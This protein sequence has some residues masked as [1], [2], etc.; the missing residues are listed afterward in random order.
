MDKEAKEKESK[1][2]EQAKET[3]EKDKPEVYDASK[4]TVLGGLDAVRKRPSMYIGSTSSTGLH[5][6]V[7]EVVDNSIDEAMAG[8]C[9]EI[10]ITLA[11]DNSVTVEDNGR[12]IPAEIHPKYKVNCIELV[13]T[14]LHAGG[15]FDKKAYKVSGGLHG[16]GVSVV[17]ALSEVLE[18]WGYRDNS[19]YYQKYCRGKPAAAVKSIGK[20]EGTRTGTKVRFLADKEIFEEGINYSNDILENSFREL[21]FLNKGLKIIFIDEKNNLRHEF[22]YEGGLRSFVEFINKNK[23]PLHEIIYLKTIK[24]DVELEVAIQY[25]NSYNENVFSFVNNINTTEGGTH[26]TGFKTALTRTLNTYAEKNFGNSDFKLTSEDVREGLAAVIAIKIPDPQFEGQTKTKLGNLNVKGIVDSMVST[27]LTTFLG[28]HPAVARGIVE[29]AVTAAKAREAARKARE[30]TRRKSALD[31]AALPGKLADC[32]EKDPANCELFLVEGDSAGGSAKQARS[33]EFQAI[34][35]LRGKILNVEKARINKV[36]SSQ[37]IVTMITA[38]GTSIAEEFDIN[39][40]RYHKIIIMTDADTDGNNIATLLLTFFFR[41]MKELIEQGY[42]Y[43]AQPPLY[44]VRKG[45]DKFY[46]LTEVDKS[47]FVKKLGE[48]ASVQR[49]KGLGEMNPEALWETT[50]DP[51]GR[52]LKKVTIGDAIAADEIFAIL[53]GDEGEPRRKFIEEHALEA[54]NID[55]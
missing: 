40:L 25:N 33:K 44:L 49:Y 27:C 43:I 24:E 22:F 4:I 47:A 7:Y 37:E 23:S 14:K 10:I 50:M 52:I 2:K 51:A 54:G 31:T 28:E 15:K 34:L 1:E 42:I 17:N 32:S 35:P 48:G 13:M 3:K 18:I 45:K 29:K 20:Y 11:K 21:A 39:K 41:Y 5:H 12:G 55:I 46:A 30:L 36:M 9:N 53:M 16:V 6:L 8:F 19:I 38:L 26:L